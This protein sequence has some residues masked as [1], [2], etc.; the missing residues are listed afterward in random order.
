[1][2]S[3]HKTIPITSY[4]VRDYNMVKGPEPVPPNRVNMQGGFWIVKP[5]RGVFEELCEILR[6]GVDYSAEGGWGGPHLMPSHY[7]GVAQI[8][9][10]LSYYYG[11]F[12][13]FSSVELNR[14]HYNNMVDN[15]N[16]RQACHGEELTRQCQD[17]RYTPL[18]KIRSIHLTLCQKPWWCPGWIK[19]VQ[20]SKFHY[21][22]HR[23]RED[24]ESLVKAPPQSASKQVNT[25][26]MTS[27]L[28]R[29]RRH[30]RRSGSKGYRPIDPSVFSKLP[31][32]SNPK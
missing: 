27:V 31:S 8:Q 28:G 17:C 20:C 22:W 26:D 3:S 16:R 13:P 9:G 30:C 10:L 15:P 2:W 1:M 24:L 18:S 32:R 19:E 25:S 29:F 6:D 4:F 21:E 11:F 14:C 7:Y 5:H 23:I 12:R